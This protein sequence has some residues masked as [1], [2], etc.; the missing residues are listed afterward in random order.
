VQS[1]IM[2][3]TVHDAITCTSS[4]SSNNNSHGSVQVDKAL[5][6][7]TAN[8]SSSPFTV[9]HVSHSSLS[10]SLCVLN[11]HFPGEPGLS[12]FIEAEDDGGGCD[13]WS[14]KSCKAPIK[15]SPPTNQHLVFLQTE[16]P[17]CRPTNSVKALKGKYHIQWTCWPQAHLGV[18]Q[19]CL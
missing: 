16:C 13:N 19:L 6:S 8:P 5:D 17:S 10:L 3:I 15:S 4:S 9:T 11:D 14:Y 7:H 18:F 1:V 2:D 12:V